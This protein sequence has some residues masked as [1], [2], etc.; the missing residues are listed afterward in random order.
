MTSQ[1]SLFLYQFVNVLKWWYRFISVI[2]RLLCSKLLSFMYLHDMFS[3]RNVTSWR[4]WIY[5][6]LHQET[7]FLYLSL[8]VCSRADP[9]FVSVIS[10]VA[11]LNF[12]IVI[13]FAFAWWNNVTK[14]RH[15]VIEHAVPISACSSARDIYFF[16]SIV[17]W[18]SEFKNIIDFIFAYVVMSLRDAMTSLTLYDATKVTLSISSCRCARKMIRCLF[19]WLFELLNQEVSS[20]LHWL[21][22][23]QWHHDHDVP[24]RYSKCH[25]TDLSLLM[26]YNRAIFFVYLVNWEIR[27]E[28]I[29]LLL[30]FH[31]MAWRYNETS[32][33]NVVTCWR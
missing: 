3:C 20:H 19:I 24:S 26:R 25:S 27:V 28:S 22:F 9:I 23:K 13:V 6:T 17:F 31:M 8:Q 1:N 29:L 18:V 2:F 33:R 4:H 5:T 14:W 21:H 7:Y 10:L 15:D 16:V 32:W 30:R 11:E 12:V